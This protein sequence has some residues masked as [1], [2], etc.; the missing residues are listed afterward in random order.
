MNPFKRRVILETVIYSPNSQP[1]NENEDNRF[2]ALRIES[3]PDQELIK[4]RGKLFCPYCYEKAAYVSRSSNGRAPHF[5]SVHRDINGNQCPEKT[6]ES[7]KVPTSGYQS[8]SALLNEE[9]V[10]KI[11]FNFASDDGHVNPR[12]PNEDDITKKKRNKGGYRKYGEAT[13]EGKS[14]WSRRL[15]TLLKT[16]KEDP[17][18]GSSTASI[19]VFGRTKPI[20]KCFFNTDAGYMKALQ[21]GKYPAFFWGSAWDAQEGSNGDVWINTTENYQDLSIKIPKKV[22][23]GLKTRYNLSDDEPHKLLNGSLFLLYGWFK[24]AK[25]SG[26]AY[27]ELCEPQTEYI[28]LK[29]S[30]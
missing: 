8:V 1:E 21:P 20:K 24:K 3:L 23:A 7:E 18:F 13:G 12:K 15:S 4:V 17:E 9:N 25:S 28:A 14:E 10:Y 22:F 29:L 16:L 2:A 5:R 11:D 27:I 30:S 26:K 6:P 19:K